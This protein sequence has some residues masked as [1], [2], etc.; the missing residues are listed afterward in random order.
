MRS[1]A[2]WRS[3]PAAL[4]AAATIVFVLM[5]STGFVGIKPGL[6]YTEPFTFLLL[7]FLLAAVLLIG[8]VLV[9][10][11]AWP[12]RSMIKHC[13][14]V[15]VLLQSVYL[16]GVFAAIDHGIPAGVVALIVGLQPLVKAV[17]GQVLLR[18]GVSARQW[19]GLVCGLAGVALV[20]GAPLIQQGAGRTVPTPLALGLASM[21]LLGGTLGTLYQRRWGRDLPLLSGTAIQFVAASA[22]MLGGALAWE[23]MQVQWTASLV[24]ALVWLVLVLSLGAVLLL[25]VLLQRT[26]AA[27]VASLF[28]LVPLATA[29]EAFVIFGERLT[30]LALVGMLIAVIGVA[31]VLLRAR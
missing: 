20:V 2:A 8:L 23:T 9:R 15:D 31:L 11:A 10:H 6:P 7:R 25:M 19:I 5:W 4:D 21:A 29:L 24:F 1:A 26:T 18:E 30:P 13:V 28:Y 14:V 22:V 16:S 17:L 3:S 12:G 27:R